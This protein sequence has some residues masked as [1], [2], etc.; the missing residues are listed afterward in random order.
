MRRTIAVVSS[1][2]AAMVLA[3]AAQA[4]PLYRLPQ[5]SFRIV[6]D[7]WN[8]GWRRHDDDGW[9]RHDHG[10]RDR[11]GRDRDGVIPEH[12]VIRLVLRQGFVSIAD[13]RLRRDRYVVR[14]VRPNGA[15][16][17][18][19][20]DAFNGDI[21]GRHRIGWGDYGGDRDWRGHAG[22]EFRFGGGRFGIYGR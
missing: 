11:D 20:I 15:L 3:G 22:S 18:L 7:E 17:Q 14:A 10:R 19:S 12:R 6:D 2:L 1:V 21:L 8:D 13:I 16:E 4:A 9:R 5:A